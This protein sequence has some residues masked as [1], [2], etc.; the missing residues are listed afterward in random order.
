M[1]DNLTETQVY[2]SDQNAVIKLPVA[3]TVAFYIGI[4]LQLQSC[5]VSY[6]NYICNDH[7]I[8]GKAKNSFQSIFIFLVLYDEMC[9]H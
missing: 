8:K 3:V 4:S 9:T 7:T 6:I 2:F 5:T 1:H